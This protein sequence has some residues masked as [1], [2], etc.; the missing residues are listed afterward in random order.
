MPDGSTFT[1]RELWK[2]PGGTLAPV[3]DATRE[4][5]PGIGSPSVGRAF[6]GLIPVILADASEGGSP[7]RSA[8]IRGAGLRAAM[9]I[10][11]VSGQERLAVLEFLSDEPIELTERLVDA[12]NAIGHEVGQFLR[13]HRGELTMV[14]LSPRRA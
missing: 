4:W 8:A 5:G 12:L 11:A 3:V 9:A 2:R 10:P 1:V 13:R 6:T 7:A 14:E